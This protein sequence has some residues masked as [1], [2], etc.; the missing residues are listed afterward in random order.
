MVTHVCQSSRAPTPHWVPARPRAARVDLQPH[1]TCHRRYRYH[2]VCGEALTRSRRS[3]SAGRTTY[4]QYSPRYARSA[5]RPSTH[6]PPLR[7]RRCSAMDDDGLWP[8]RE[9]DRSVQAP[10]ASG[11]R[12]AGTVNPGKSDHP[13]VHRAIQEIGAADEPGDKPRLRPVVQRHRIIHLL[14]PAMVHHHDAVGGH[15]RL[16]LVMRHIDR[17]DA[18]RVVQAAD[19]RAHLLAQIGVQVGQRFVE[20][21]H[22]RL[23]HDGTRQR[24]ALLLAAGQ[25]GRIAV[26]QMA[27]LHHIEDAIEPLVQFVAPA[28]CAASGRTRR[29]APPSC[30]AR[31]RSSGRSSTCRAFPARPRGRATTAPRRSSR[32]CRRSG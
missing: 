6:Q 19:F 12:P 10:S 4:S 28:A 24:D 2:P 8:D 25:L 18:E 26:L 32:S 5:M 11:A 15:H 14:D 3:D 16:G 20:Q 27:Q 1:T 22:F 7:I 31:S 29:S 23:D 21:Q 30:S 17:G 13:A 9:T